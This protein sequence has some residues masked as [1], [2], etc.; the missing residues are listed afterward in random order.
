MLFVL[1]QLA[2]D[3]YALDATQVAEV[4]P[5]LAVKEIPL[6]P[7]GVAGVI[8]YRGVPVPVVD[9]SALTLGRVAARRLSTRIILLHYGGCDGAPQ[10]LGVIA[11]K[12]TDILRCDRAEFKSSG[13]SNAETPYLGPVSADA[14]G[15]IQ[16]IEIDKLLSPAVRDVLFKLPAPGFS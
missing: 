10:L 9:L 12:A 1:F 15:L 4:L 16:W 2:N 11:E 7:V 6:A 14:R 3:R 13:I 5:L 8:N